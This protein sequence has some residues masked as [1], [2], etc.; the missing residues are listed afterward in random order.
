MIH[1]VTPAA[2][3]DWDSPG[4]RLYAVPFTFDGTWGRMRL[5]LCV[6]CGPKPGKTVVAIG[7]TH[8]NEYEG[9]VGLKHLIA[10][11]TAD[12]V[13][14]GRLIVIP[15]LNV[16]A[17]AAA[18][19]E[20][21]ADGGNMNRAFPGRADG[22]LTGRVAHFVATEVI[23][24]GDV[25][26][27]IHAAGDTHEIARCASFH[28]VDDR[29]HLAAMRETGALFGMPWIWIYARGM[30]AGLLTEYA[31]SLG[32]ITIGGEFGYGAS[33]DLQGVRWA[34]RGVLNVMRHHG[35]MP[36]AVEPLLP[37]EYDKQRF[38]ASTDLDAWMTAPISGI[39]EPLV[40]LGAFVK[41]GQP[42]AVIHDFE[43]IDEPGV[44]IRA[45]M[46]GYLLVRHFRAATPQGAVV[47]VIGQEVST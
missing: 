10:G 20:S 32:K 47:A 6:V 39:S 18:R 14:A 28:L 30:G 29:A 8:G 1:D 4:K 23:P 7:G 43:R 34:H 27:D 36:G 33:T 41:Q 35:L 31:E 42:V 19:R 12:T 13:Q 2:Q 15:V 37:P 9:P 3:I 11:I 5:P 21:P 25:V 16:P 24:R 46:D 17:F 26:V 38:V 40:P 22:T 45:N 44:E